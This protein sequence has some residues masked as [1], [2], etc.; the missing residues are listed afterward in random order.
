MK[1]LQGSNAG[2]RALALLVLIVALLP[3]V[4]GSSY[5][6]R[7]AALVWIM[8]LAAVGLHIL[9]GMAGQISLGHAGFFG[10][11]AYA[12]A[13]LPA[14]YGV[15]VVV[16]AAGGIVL[17]GLIAYLVGKPI[18]RLKGHYLA[19]ATLGFSLLIGLVI[20]S[21]V[22]L[23]GGPDGMDVKRL[24]IAGFA[25]ES[26]ST[27]YWISAA[28][29]I[30]GVAVA[31]VLRD[32]PTGRA[33]RAILDSEVAAASMGVDVA[34]RKLQAFVIA[35]VY[36]AVAGSTLALMNG[37]I[38]PDL[39]GFMTSVE[40]V[41]MVVIGGAATPFGAL[42]GAALLTL[43]PQLLA[44]FHDY[45]DIAVGLIIMLSMIFLRQGIVPTLGQ[46]L[47]RASK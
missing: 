38:T 41:A 32:S 35:S 4:A 39:A 36:A 43:L 20:T 24:G 13:V 10:I 18:L 19:I 7:I 3:V 12:S 33:L 21:E 42:V 2:W 34:R 11:G 5:V 1:A 15:P 27:W 6:M 22:A 45:Q 23:T 40:F 9:M 17:A 28:L 26:P 31:M 29:M 37:F 44:S 46:L 8:G 47:R 14:R 16:A 25:L 30:A